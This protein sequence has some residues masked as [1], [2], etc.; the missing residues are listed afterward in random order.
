MI[1]IPTPQSILDNDRRDVFEEIVPDTEEYAAEKRRALWSRYA[2]R[3][4]GSC[5]LEYW[6]KAMQYRYQEISDMYDLQWR[7]WEQWLA[8][9]AGTIDMTDG[10]S[11]YK[12]VTGTEDNPDNPQGDTVY[13]SDR[14]TV[15]YNG[16]QSGGLSIERVVRFRDAVYSIARMFSDE[17]REQFYHGV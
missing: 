1:C 9:N 4:I 8:A 15:E 7:A 13:L 6:I 17:F 14:V 10:S 2:Y 16:K 3:G 12:T 5:D 11:E